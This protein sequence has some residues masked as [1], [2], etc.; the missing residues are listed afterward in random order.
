MKFERVLGT[1]TGEGF[2]ELSGQQY[3]VVYEIQSLGN[4][5]TFKVWGTLK[6]IPASA[7]TPLPE[8]DRV[9]LRLKDGAM[10]GIAIV[11][12]APCR[13]IVNTPMPSLD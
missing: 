4:S 10:V 13:I 2:V 7:I 5:N 12:P 3:P 9:P 1:W 6:G 8:G 11:N